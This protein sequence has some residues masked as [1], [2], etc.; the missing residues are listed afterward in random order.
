MFFR[1][2]VRLGKIPKIFIRC[3]R[4]IYS[5]DNQDNINGE[6]RLILVL[7][8]TYTIAKNKEEGDR[9]IYYASVDSEITKGIRI[10]I[11]EFFTPRYR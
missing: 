10:T 8:Q 4:Y 1:G 9:M 3:R 11:G 5:W 6:Q 2:L 7:T